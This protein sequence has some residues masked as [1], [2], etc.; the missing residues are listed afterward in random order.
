MLD[1]AVKKGR[2]TPEKRDALLAKITDGTDAAL[3]QAATS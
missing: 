3:L 1:K 2:S